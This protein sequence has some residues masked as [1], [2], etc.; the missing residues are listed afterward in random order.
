MF[1]HNLFASDEHVHL[2]YDIVYIRRCMSSKNYL[3]MISPPEKN[4]NYGEKT[5]Q[6]FSS[7]EMDLNKVQAETFAEMK[8]SKKTITPTYL[9]CTFCQFIG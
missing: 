2:Q 6:N 1:E 7:S 3:K 8:E 5:L 9:L 4:I